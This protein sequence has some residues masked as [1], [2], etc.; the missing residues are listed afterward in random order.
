MNEQ[1]AG[2]SRAQGIE[3]SKL[4]LLIQF[5]LSVGLTLVVVIAVLMGKDISGLSIVAGGSY[6]SDGAITSFYLWKAKT[7]NRAK[8][9]ERFALRAAKEYGIEAALQLT[10]IIVK[11]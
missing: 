4:A 7:E 8:Y 6:V 11:D 2:G 10:E 5:M 3:F 9:A 1:R